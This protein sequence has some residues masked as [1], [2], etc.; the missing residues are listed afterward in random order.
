MFHVSTGRLGA[1]GK[2]RSMPS[3]V[4]LAVRL[5]D[6]QARISEIY[7]QLRLAPGDI[8]VCEAPTTMRDPRAAL[9]VEQVRGVFESVA[10]ELGLRVPGRINPRTVQ[11]D[12]MGLR[13]KQAGRPL[14]KQAAVQ[15]A[16]ALYSKELDLIGF[17]TSE[18]NMKRNQDIVDAL[19]IG[20]LGLVWLKAAKQAGASYEEYF[21]NAAR[22]RRTG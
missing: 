2:L 15:V 18:T 22:M 5:G 16:R 1:V 20:N 9:K 3:S 8:V 17:P 11:S 13:G 6:L 4:P 19:L 10:R 12:V 7:R 14:V 21:G